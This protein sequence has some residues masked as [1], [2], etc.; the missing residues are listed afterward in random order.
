MQCLGLHFN[1][2]L[3]HEGRQ[4]QNFPL[5]ML[6]LKKFLIFKYF[7]FLIRD[8]QRVPDY[9]SKSKMDIHEST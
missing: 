4:V 9:H 6:M 7:R 1:C 3:L 8:T 2:N 5:V